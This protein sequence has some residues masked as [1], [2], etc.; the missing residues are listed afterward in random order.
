MQLLPLLL[1]VGLVLGLLLRLWTQ[2][3]LALPLPP[4]LGVEVALLTYSTF[5]LE[6]QQTPT[7]AAFICDQIGEL[8]DSR[9]PFRIVQI[10]VDSED[11]RNDVQID[12]AFEAQL[13]AE[14]PRYCSSHIL[15]PMRY[16]TDARCH[17]A[18]LRAC[19][20]QGHAVQIGDMYK[21]AFTYF[22]SIW[23][24]ATPYL[25][26]VDTC[27]RIG[28]N[29]APAK[30]CVMRCQRE[31]SVFLQFATLL[32][33]TYPEYYAVDLCTTPAT[34]LAQFRPEHR[35][36]CRQGTEYISLQF[37][38]LDVERVRAALPLE[39]SPTLQTEHMLANSASDTFR[40]FT[41]MA[42]SVGLQKRHPWHRPAHVYLTEELPKRLSKK[43]KRFFT[44][45]RVHLPGAAERAAKL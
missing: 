45:R 14:L 9:V 28:E 19:W 39:A 24:C 15:E 29:L 34:L 36:A 41:V 11:K 31:P 18:C 35:E 20:T 44:Q 6:K 17:R 5:I 25:L 43:H 37:A 33:S 3:S 40:C 38:L 23:R 13:S 2:R 32:L 8:H 30:P 1:C 4:V 12:P 16:R 22:W 21:N 7:I 10:L 26:H 42:C 27:V